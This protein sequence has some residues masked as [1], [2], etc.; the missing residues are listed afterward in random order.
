MSL[1]TPRA[2]SLPNRAD[3]PVV[4]SGTAAR[5]KRPWPAGRALWPPGAEGPKSELPPAHLAGLWPPPI[6]AI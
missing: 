1:R 2:A 3:A 4:A 5:P 6:W